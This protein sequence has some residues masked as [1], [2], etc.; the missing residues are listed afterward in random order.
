MHTFTHGQAAGVVVEEDLVLASEALVHSR[1]TGVLLVEPC[2][3]HVR[4]GLWIKRLR[5]DFT[6]EIRDLLNAALLLRPKIGTGQSGAHQQ[7]FG[8][9]QML[10]LSI[11]V[12]GLS[13]EETS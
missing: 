5:V 1:D 3:L 8:H 12:T 11:V 9:V 7:S 4:L 6:H 2:A 13:V 10:R